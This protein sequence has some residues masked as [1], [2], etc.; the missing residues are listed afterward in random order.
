MMKAIR[1]LL[2]WFLARPGAVFLTGF[3]L[4]VVAAALDSAPGTLIAT[5]VAFAGLV[6]GLRNIW[7]RSRVQ[8]ALLGVGVPV[9]MSALFSGLGRLAP[10]IAVLFAP[11]AGAVVL[12][13]VARRL[14]WT[15]APQPAAAS[16]PYLTV[17]PRGCLVASLLAG[18]LALAGVSLAL[19][20]ARRLDGRFALQPVLHLTVL[21]LIFGSLAVYLLLKKY[22]YFDSGYQ[23]DYLWN[24]IEVGTILRMQLASPTNAGRYC[25]VMAF[26]V[27]K[28]ETA[29]ILLAGP[30]RELSTRPK[31]VSGQGQT[32]VYAIADNDN[33]TIDL[34]NWQNYPARSLSSS[35]PVINLNESKGWHGTGG[36]EARMSGWMRR[37][38]RVLLVALVTWA[39][40][41]LWRCVDGHGRAVRARRNLSVGM[42]AAETFPAAADWLDVDI[43]PADERPSTPSSPDRPFDVIVNGRGNYW[44]EGSGLLP[45]QEVTSKERLGQML[46]PLFSQGRAW[47]LTFAYDGLPPARLVVELDPRGRIA[48]ISD[49]Q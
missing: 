28:N 22:D 31:F 21:M 29:R 19:L 11:A 6:Q 5:F 45:D 32:V 35:S 44:I 47:H 7:H 46:M 27:G 3:G 18:V 9:A 49:V 2:R 17:S 48:S 42:T 38:V 13:L 15:L 36:R 37:V 10:E 14:G 12:E 26:P 33:R 16:L 23:R 34:A 24:G 30:K 41:G 39:L 20:L 4:A 25:A 40:L 8:A 43:R 1:F